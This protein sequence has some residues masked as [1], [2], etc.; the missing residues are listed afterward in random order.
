MRCVITDIGALIYSPRRL[1][2]ADRTSGFKNVA[3]SE[4]HV[5]VWDSAAACHDLVQNVETLRTS[6]RKITKTDYYSLPI[7]FL[8]NRFGLLNVRN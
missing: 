6:N 2:R 1:S 3:V 4:S 7:I 5:T 8:I